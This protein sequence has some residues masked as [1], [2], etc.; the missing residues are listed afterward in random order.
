MTARWYFD[1]VSPFS[2]LHWQKMRPLVDAGRVEAVPI[3]FGAVL[4]A[5]GQRGPAEIP[6]KRGFIYRQALWQAGR[7]G[8]RLR[9]PPAH[10]F[11]PLPALRLCVAAG[12]TTTAIDAIFD[13]IWGEGQA[14]DTAESLAGIAA[15][16]G[17]A[18][19]AAAL[20]DPAVKDRLRAGTDAALAAGV[21]GVPTLDL[22]GE[23]LWGNDSHDLMLAALEDPALLRE[24][25]L[26][27]VDALPVGIER[28]R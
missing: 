3:V 21:F 7:E 9:F 6:K 5:L 23:L 12:A 13:G 11:N 20:A 18:D 27:G 2:Y 28:R 22:D 15:S 4:H 8:V 25:A 1:F 17:I 24:G 14:L 19:P 10:P 26:A 16:L